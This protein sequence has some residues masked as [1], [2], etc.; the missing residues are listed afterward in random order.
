LGIND[1]GT[2]QSEI[3]LVKKYL[4]KK[5]LL[6]STCGANMS[7]A[8]LTARRFKEAIIIIIIIKEAIIKEAIIKEGGF[9]SQL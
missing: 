7:F 4:T 8:T 1:G 9:S 3:F 2:F 6:E 5:K